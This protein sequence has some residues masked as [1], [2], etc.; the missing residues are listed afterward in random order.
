MKPKIAVYTCITNSYDELIEPKVT[1]DNCDFIC[2]TDNDNL[3]SDTW[4]IKKVTPLYTEPVRDSRRYK[5][6]PHEYHSPSDFC[7]NYYSNF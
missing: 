5:I 7:N 6:K 2:F 1:P 3:K 4:Q